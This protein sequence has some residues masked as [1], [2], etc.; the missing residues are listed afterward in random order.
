MELKM[1]RAVLSPALSGMY[2]KENK[3]SELAG[4]VKVGRREISVQ[5]WS[6]VLRVTD[7]AS[8]LKMGM[9]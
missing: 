1:I 9:V 8:G 3:P 2:S 4:T 6:W 5:F 7:V